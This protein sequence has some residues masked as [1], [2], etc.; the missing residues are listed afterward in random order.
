L[1]A[2]SPAGSPPE[3][4]SDSLD[5]VADFCATLDRVQEF[6]LINYVIVCNVLR[7]YMKR[8]G[9]GTDLEKRLQAKLPA[10]MLYSTRPLL[11]LMSKA[12]ALVAGDVSVGKVMLLKSSAGRRQKG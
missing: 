2:C 8:A 3:A 1:E 6:V 12:E 5:V 4:S 7:Y 9:V 11:E 10:T